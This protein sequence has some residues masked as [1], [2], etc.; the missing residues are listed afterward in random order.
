MSQAAALMTVFEETRA[1]F[2]RL[3]VVV[4]QIHKQGQMSGGLRGVLRSLFA[5]GPQTVPQMARSRPTSRQHIQVLVNRLL[6]LGLVELVDNPAHK[7]SRLVSLTSAGRKRINAMNQ[8][9]AALLKKLP[10]DIPEKDLHKTVRTMKRLREL[11]EGSKWLGILSD[12]QKASFTVRRSS[13][14]CKMT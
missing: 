8:R 14:D 1:L 10:V 5:E 6:E 9:E 7:R 12:K 3:K 11:F 2:H 4:E 13:P